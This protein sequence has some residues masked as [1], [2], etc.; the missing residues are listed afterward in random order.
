[1]TSVT[2]KKSTE[3]AGVVAKTPSQEIIED[4]NRI[5]RVVDVL[6]RKIGVRKVNMSMRRRIFKALS[7]A[8]GDKAAYVNLCVVASAVCEIDGEEIRFPS[9]EMQ[10]DA[11]IDRIGD[12]GEV[13][14]ARAYKEFAS[15]GVDDQGEA[16]N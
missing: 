7:A 9:T 12:E 3:D 5:V 1:M 16:K 2:V 13:A 14:V 11:L 4:A 8:S 15:V 10:F 6:G